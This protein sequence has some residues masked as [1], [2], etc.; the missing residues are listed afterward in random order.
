MVRSLVAVG[1]GLLAVLLAPVAVPAA[2]PS[3]QTALPPP[4]L[5]VVDTLST[6][7][8]TVV[9]TTT[10]TVAGSTFSGA[11]ADAGGIPSGDMIWGGDDG[12]WPSGCR[13]VDES[14]EQDSWLFG[15]LLFRFHQ[16]K[17]WCWRG[18][19]VYD[20]R[21]NW[22]YEGG[23]TSCLDDVY[24]DN[25]WYYTWWYGVP[26]SGHYSQEHAHVSNCILRYGEWK[27]FYPSVKIWS[28][29]DGSYDVDSSS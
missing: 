14:T 16:Q 13:D 19:Y 9:G 20:E 27:Q 24:E 1:A 3:R 2:P 8:G 28:H 25:A 18:G 23:S 5:T 17:H 26:D 11:A 12:G 7:D 29:A 10:R 4:V 15:T 21:H 6:T 22:D